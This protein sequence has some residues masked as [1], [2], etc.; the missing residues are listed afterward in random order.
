[1]KPVLAIL[2]DYQGVALSSADFDSL[3][4]HFDIRV[5]TR[6]FDDEQETITELADAEVV[7]AMR[8]RT[9]L[10]REVLDGLPNLRF[11][12]TT[13]TRNAAID[14]VAA[15]ERGV[16]VS[17]TGMSKHAAGEHT[18]ALL[19][20]AARHI[21]A[22]V[23]NVRSGGWQTTVGTELYGHT[24]GIVGLGHIGSQVARYAQAF[25]MTLQAWSAN[26]D[27][28][29][30]RALG[31]TP[32]PKDRL[33]AESDIVT[34]HLVLSERTSGVVGAQELAQLGPHG[35]LVNTSRGP[36]VDEA[37]LVAALTD[38]TLG[39][40]ALDVFDDEPLPADHPLRTLP[41]VVATPHVGFVTD[42][43][44]GVAYPQAVENIH[45][46]LRGEPIRLL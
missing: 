3:R 7:V 11:I 36:L 34:L 13:G 8:E 21:P 38:G 33:F 39:A 16:P 4:E 44:Y 18:W 5:Y 29:R 45:A 12:V 41:N 43:A 22:E 30:A 32:V 26:L 20:A 24:L 25:G 42:K 2:N 9:R 37:A 1:V 17:G 19:M 6:A 40:A 27:P 46:W 31:V 14:I 28:D 10:S 35:L 15:A 23:D